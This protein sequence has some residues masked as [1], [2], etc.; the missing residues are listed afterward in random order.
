MSEQKRLI[1]VFV[2]RS[3]QS[4]ESAEPKTCEGDRRRLCD[5][6][7]ERVMRSQQ[8]KESAE[9]QTCEGDRRRLCDLT[10]ERAKTINYR[11]C[12]AKSTKQGKNEPSNRRRSF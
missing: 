11:F 9:P 4:K 10:G 6:T 12:D 3:Q 2:M 8:S 1:I 7:G 5:L